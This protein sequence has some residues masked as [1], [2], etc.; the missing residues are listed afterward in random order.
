MYSM[1]EA[2]RTS[3]LEMGADKIRHSGRTFLEHL[4]GTRALLVK[5]NAA[6]EVAV[7]GLVHSAYGT[8]AFKH[9][10]VERGDR[11]ALQGLI[12]EPAERLVFLFCGDARP[13]A[14]KHQDWHGTLVARLARHFSDRSQI[15]ETINALI[16]IECANLIEQG[17][18][19]GSDFKRRLQEA[20]HAG[21]LCLRMEVQAAIGFTST[22][23]SPNVTPASENLTTTGQPLVIRK[24]EARDKT[25]I[26]K[27]SRELVMEGRYRRSWFD[28]RI[29]GTSFD[30]YCERPDHVLLAAFLG[31]E[32]IGFVAGHQ[33]SSLFSADKSAVVSAL[34]VR[35][36]RAGVAGLRL[37]LALRSWA[38][39]QGAQEL[40][41][42]SERHG[43]GP[44]T[45]KFYKKIGLHESGSMHAMWLK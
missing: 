12:G 45:E 9:A 22:A 44:R 33:E 30:R 16:E 14:V 7:A 27:M 8:N 1:N 43:A 26:L 28:A 36:W 2:H 21:H 11:E 34:Y 5:W 15:V 18:F 40:L 25:A 37:L 38:R 17:A 39:Q 13:A 3:L 41:A 6:E 24:A 20:S 19:S 4:E 29:A 23:A 31:E 32:P 42:P 10:L 35:R